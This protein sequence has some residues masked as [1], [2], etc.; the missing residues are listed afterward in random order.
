MAIN[1]DSGSIDGFVKVLHGQSFINERF[2]GEVFPDCYGYMLLAFGGYIDFLFDSA[3]NLISFYF[4]PFLIQEEH[5]W[6]NDWI[7]GTIFFMA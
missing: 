6:K 3:E 4:H 2:T 5:K 1:F 7:K